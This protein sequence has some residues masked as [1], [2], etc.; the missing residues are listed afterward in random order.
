MEEI[1][2]TTE[3]IQSG[4]AKDAAGTLL[5]VAEAIRAL[6]QEKRIG[7]MAELVGMEHSDT[8]AKLVDKPDELQRQMA[9]ANSAQA[10]GSMSRE[11]AARNA[12]L[13]AQMVM[14]NNRVFNAMSTAGESLKDTIISVLQTVNPLLER[15]TAWMKANPG[16]VGGVLKV[17]V[18]LGLLS[19]TLGAVL[20]AV[21]LL[22]VKGMLLR[23]LLGRLFLAFSGIGGAVARMGPWLLRAAQWL[24]AWGATL[25]TYMPA[26]LRF[27]MV[28]LRIAT[29]P[30]G[31]LA[32]AATM[33]Y[34]R[35]ADVVGGLKLL[36][37]DIGAAVL[38]AAQYVWGLGAQFFEAGA[39]IVQGMANGITSRI[40]AV[41]DA[42]SMAAGD[43]VDLFKEKLG[44]HSPSR[45]FMQ[46]G[47]YVGE[48]AALGIQNGAG[49]VRQAA[50]GMATASMVPMAAMGAPAAPGA[51]AGSSYQ[52][53]INAAPG[54]DGQDI[55]RAV[56][57]ELDRRERD[58]DS[59]R[60]SRLSD[61]D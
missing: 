13:S 20:I 60:Y 41:R 1:G 7:V 53:T 3:A 30:V 23:L 44:I 48:G 11:A 8:L 39:A 54:M 42:I 56:S 25:A 40:S 55:A 58:K 59:R 35:W 29:G 32:L 38:A 24:G 27:G 50:L 31:L 26:M 43:A 4:M 16:I 57:A 10:K 17:V 14:F 22:M 52:I 49:L 51:T 5:K 46:L 61:I 36:M 19:V 33:L 15:F 6:P 2:M 18:G 37:Q 34:S 45:V 47:S 9:L 12:T 21:G 28:L